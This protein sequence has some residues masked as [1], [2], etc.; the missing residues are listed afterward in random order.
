MP[1]LSELTA[2]PK[3]VPID[4]FDPIYWNNLTI[5]ERAQY[6]KED[7]YI[8]LPPAELCTTWAECDKWKNMPQKE[9][10]A[11][12]GDEVLAEYNLPTPAELERLKKG[13]EEDEEDEVQQNL[14]QSEGSGE[15]GEE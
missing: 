10:M 15:S 13:D 4:W 7:T 1:K 9:F 8:A 11:K 6:M 12:Y 3:D 14:E 2:L 5:R